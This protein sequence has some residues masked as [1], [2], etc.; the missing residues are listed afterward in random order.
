MPQM[1]DVR[2]VDRAGDL[3]MEKI[4]SMERVVKVAS[5]K[6]FFP[7]DKKIG[8]VFYDVKSPGL[9][10]F[11]AFQ[12][13]K[14]I[15][16]EKQIQQVNTVS[17]VEV[18]DDDLQEV[19]NIAVALKHRAIGTSAKIEELSEITPSAVEEFSA[20]EIDYFKKFADN[21]SDQKKKK[22]K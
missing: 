13:Q 9:A 2:P 6:Y 3:D 20:E 5:R 10:D 19:K 12:F 4:Q 15:E 11:Q 22:K 8:D 1:F 21:H 17:H 14:E 18:G 7:S 16:K